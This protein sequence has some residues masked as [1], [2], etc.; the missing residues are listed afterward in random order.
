MSC[1]RGHMEHLPE[2]ARREQILDVAHELV[3]EVGYHG[4]TMKMVAERAGISRAWLYRFFEDAESLTDALFRR[5]ASE[6]IPL[7]NPIERLDTGLVEHVMGRFQQVLDLPRHV[8]W[9]VY[10][11]YHAP[12]GAA[13]AQMTQRRMVLM[14]IEHDWSNPLISLGVSPER[15]ATTT[16]TLIA[17]M[18]ALRRLVEEGGADQ[19]G[20]R[21]TFAR[22]LEPLV[23]SR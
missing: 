8:F 18:F 3:S 21:A 6:L 19:D 14:M 12:E 9:N 2:D 20:A 1:N 22:S 23:L 16:H 13:P 7:S 4:L 11:A 15:A 17:S 10:A 5:T